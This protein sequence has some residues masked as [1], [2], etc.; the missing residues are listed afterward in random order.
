[1]DVQFVPAQTDGPQPAK[2]TISAPAAIAHFMLF[3]AIVTPARR[4][5]SL[6]QRLPA[7]TAPTQRGLL[8]AAATGVE[9]RAAAWGALRLAGGGCQERLVTRPAFSGC[10]RR[11]AG[12]AHFPGRT[13]GSRRRREWVGAR[14][15]E[16]EA[17]FRLE[18]GT[19]ST[20]E[21]V[22]PPQGGGRGAGRS[23]GPGRLKARPSSTMRR[24]PCRFPCR[25][26]RPFL[27]PS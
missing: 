26:C 13:R 8:A 2:P 11:R 6:A 1:M 7:A 25:R 20:R 5:G 15:A 17:W 24:A 22:V 10:C 19:P 4:R 23:A 27:P 9:A 21:A 18:K 3:L 16:N 14:V 12:S